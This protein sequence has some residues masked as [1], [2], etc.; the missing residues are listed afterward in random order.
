M[1]PRSLIRTGIA[2]DTIVAVTV[3]GLELSNVF[4]FEAGQRRDAVT[5]ALLALSSLPLI[6]WR[7]YPL[8]CM[9]ITGWATIALAAR[10]D[11]HLGLGA[12]A[13]TY[14]VACWEESNAARWFAASS[15]AIAVWLVP[16]L[17]S[18][19]GSIPTNVALFGAAW[20][21]GALIRDRRRQTAALQARTVEL[22]DER[23]A[24]AA[25][26]AEAERS[27]IAHELHDVLTH[28]V[29]VMV[30]QAQ[31][32]QA[33]APDTGAMTTALSRIETIG[34]QTLTDLR[35]LLLRIGRPADAVREPQPSLE[36][37]DELVSSVHSA[38]IDV[39]VARHGSIREVPASVALAAY[40]IIQEALTN[41]IRHAPGSHACVTLDYGA[42]E[43][44]ITVVNDGPI[45]GPGPAAD[46]KGLAGM[47]HRVTALGGTIIAGPELEGGFRLV[48]TVPLPTA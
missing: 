47:R 25:L 28:S 10:H 23:E 19:R 37:V 41:T 15:L 21:L 32:G 35:G 12:I 43:L 5:I 22:A 20:I 1:T 30:V 44:A 11:P 36:H 40:R 7:R 45:S 17:T 46:G 8:A 31:G 2:L 27:R 14:A 24:N 4:A 26:A 48:A 29:T 42:T 39:T 16:I 13:A 9:Q 6:V 34:Q 18:D 38:G 3:F 33:A